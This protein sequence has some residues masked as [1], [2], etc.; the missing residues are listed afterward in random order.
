MSIDHSYDVSSFTTA[1]EAL[2][3]TTGVDI[4][5]MDC[6]GF[7]VY[8][9]GVSNAITGL[10]VYWSNDA[11]GARWSV[12]DAD[13]AAQFAAAGSSLAAS[14]GSFRVERTGTVAK[15]IRITVSAGSATTATVDLLAF[16][17]GVR[18]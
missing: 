13:I 3:G 10:S 17:T 18:L 7:T 8:N 15:R 14:T 2:G 4:T 6:V 1:V 11:A 12:A 16:Q 5:G 9:T